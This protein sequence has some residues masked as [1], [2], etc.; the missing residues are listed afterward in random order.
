MKTEKQIYAEKIKETIRKG[1]PKDMSEFEWKQYNSW[2]KLKIK[3]LR[4]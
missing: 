2:G 3:E 4:E 1:K